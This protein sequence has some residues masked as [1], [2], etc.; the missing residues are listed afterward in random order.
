MHPK[1]WKNTLIHLRKG[2]IASGN[3]EV[4]AEIGSIINDRANGFARI[5]ASLSD[6]QNGN[7]ERFIEQNVDTVAS[8]EVFWAMN[9]DVF[10][11]GSKA[12]TITEK[13]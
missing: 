2:A 3:F 5:L 6:R 8:S 1:S 11:S 13:G 9:Q 10:L 4:P 7:I 12:F